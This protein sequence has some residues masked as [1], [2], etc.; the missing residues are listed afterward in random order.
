M[1]AATCASQSSD[2][3]LFDRLTVS[4]D[5][6][7]PFGRFND[8]L[9]SYS[10]PNEP[11]PL[12]FQQSL[13]TFLQRS[14]NHLTKEQRHDH[15]SRFG[16]ADIDIESL[17]TI[18]SS[19]EDI[20]TLF[21]FAGLSSSIIRHILFDQTKHRHIVNLAKLSEICPLVSIPTLS[22]DLPFLFRSFLC[23]PLAYIFSDDTNRIDSFRPFMDLLC[24]EFLATVIL[25]CS[26]DVN[27]TFVTYFPSFS[28]VLSQPQ[29]QR[30]LPTTSFGIFHKII[31]ISSKYNDPVTKMAASIS[32]LS[33]QHFSA[34]N[35]DKNY[36]NTL[37]CK[38][39]PHVAKFLDAHPDLVD[40]FLI[41]I[42]LSSSPSNI[43]FR[44][45]RDLNLISA[46]SQSS[47]PIFTKLSEPLLDPTFHLDS[48]LSPRS[49]TDPASSFIRMASTN[50]TFFCRIVETH[51]KHILDIAISTAVNSFQAVYDSP[52]DPRRLDFG[53]A[54]QNWVVLLKT[55]AEVKMD[56]SQNGRSFNS[57][58]SSLLSLLVLF[59]ASVD[60]ELST[61]A[62]SVFS[63]QFGLSTPHT[64][65]LL[66]ATPTTFPVG[67]EFRQRLPLVFG[68]PDHKSGSCKSICAEASYC[69][70]MQSHSDVSFAGKHT[71]FMRLIGIDFTGCLV[72]ALHSTAS[73]P[74]S[75]PFFSLLLTDES[76]HPNIWND[77][78]L[79]SPLTGLTTLAE[80]T[81]NLAFSVSTG[82]RK[83]SQV[84][85]ERRDTN[86]VHLFPFLGTD[87]QTFFLLSF[88]SIFQWKKQKVHK[89]LVG[90][91]EYLIEM[92]TVTSY[93]T[94]IS[95]LIAS[96]KVAEL[97]HQISQIEQS[98]VDKLKTAEGEE[99]W[100]LLTQLIVVAR[101]TPDIANEL[102]KAENDAQALLIL[103]VHTIRSCP[104]LNLHLDSNLAVFDRVVEFTGH[105]NNLPL[106]AA[107][108]FHIADTVDKLN[109]PAVIDM[110]FNGQKKT[111]LSDL[112]LNTLREI[113]PLRREGVE[114]GWVVGTDCVTSK[115]VGSCLT[116][117]SF[118]I[119]FDTFN[120]TPFVDS[121]VSLAVTADLSLLRSILL[122]LQH[123][124]ERTCRTSTPFSISTA[125]AP[126]RGIHE[127]S[128]TQQP[129]LSIVSSKCLSASLSTLAV[130]DPQV[131]D[132]SLLS[133]FLPG[134]NQNL[135]SEIAMEITKNV[136]LILEERRAISSAVPTSDDSSG[137][138]LN[139]EFCD[140]PPQQ[141]FLALHSMIFPDDPT[142]ASV[143]TL[144]SLAPFL[145]RIL[146]IVV[147]STT[148]R[149]EILVL[150]DEQEQLLNSFLSL[151]LSLINTGTPSTLSTPPL[152]S[153]LSV[154]SIA[155]VRL[156]TIPSS[157]DLHPR[158]CQMFKQRGNQSNPNVR[159][160][161]HS[162]CSEGMEDRNDV[163]LDLFSLE[164]LN[165]WMGANAQPGPDHLLEIRLEALRN[166]DE[167]LDGPLVYMLNEA[168]W[169]LNDVTYD[170]CVID[171][172]DEE[173]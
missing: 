13:V 20:C 102:L 18:V 16:A 54:T 24:N 61:V 97:V 158:F 146:T 78:R 116:V 28:K 57:F 166:P 75:F 150:Q 53:R 81:L 139:H 37:L 125:T 21:H 100:K 93:N 44:H 104:P 149:V 118:L 151:I 27:E 11:S 103:S 173:P 7:S 86:I 71:D 33:N 162:L 74:H 69:V 46:L 79:P 120:P 23:D 47:S 145:T 119:R 38:Y 5:E 130:S 84:E 70:V 45:D 17:A 111:T 169:Y 163:T 126:F 124:E 66:F 101:E 14:L 96:K 25:G 72:N 8:L 160:F 172:F 128:V 3:D 19:H 40:S 99:R 94:P 90:V 49:F 88:S 62:V 98:I 127:S 107:A 29:F 73:L 114:E 108:L 136:C 159:L 152:S 48:L 39:L 156:D 171:D 6:Y 30:I 95:L 112:I 51:A 121:L 154:L 137:I 9:D 64:E 157:L 142:T 77:T 2:S 122:V 22:K 36:Q 85:K 50:S 91:V 82:D 138:T 42:A 110:V 1:T 32:H 129:L 164:F 140:T 4:D 43:L 56:L 34:T 133:Q 59:A 109:S 35:D 131:A 167:P 83:M 58:P 165:K 143:S 76:N 147:P 55:I 15:L 117:L 148:D 155:L 135:I 31:E 92:A 134:V 144:I 106:V 105:L 161:V 41:T 26:T 65:A 123:I 89:S 168:V 115:I 63:N 52:S 67:D 141:L 170:E 68:D 132:S 12:L 60:D 87:S 113:Y 10:D 153:F 80:T